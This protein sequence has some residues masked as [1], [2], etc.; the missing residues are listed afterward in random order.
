MFLKRIKSDLLNETFRNGLFFTLFSFINK[1]ISFV[2]LIIL[3]RY[4]T[5]TEYGYWSLFGTVVM[6]IGYFMAMTTEGYISISYFQEGLNG[7]KKTFSCI[8]FT[9][10]I[11]SGLLF[12]IVAISKKSLEQVLDLPWQ[13]LFLAVSIAFFTV[14]SNVYLDFLRIQKNIVLYGLFSCG[15]AL[16]VLGSSLVFV[17]YFLMGWKGCALAQFL[18]FAIFGIVGLCYFSF[19]KKLSIPNK[20]HWIAMLRWG[21]PLIP[22]LA[23]TFIRLGC[24]RYIINHFYSLEMVGIFSFAYALAMSIST[25]GMGFNEANS[26]NIYEILGNQKITI[27]DKIRLLKKQKKIVFTVYLCGFILITFLCFITI[28]L[29]FPKYSSSITYF[30]ILAFFAFLQCLY[31]LY[32]N[33]LFYFK[34][35]SKLMCITFSF[36]FIHL[37]LSLCFTCYSVYYTCIIYFLTQLGVV[38]FVRK[39]A[40][41]LLEQNFKCNIREF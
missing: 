7:V 39:E 26:I 34:S 40:I 17:K 30:V 20:T 4:I 28:P 10:L 5:P 27:F 36:A 31:F 3:A 8:L 14:F 6:F 18:G 11:V 21:L 15:N 22:H 38:I 25:I 9:A 13:Y 24:D 19:S 29:A 35:T 2:L 33:F 23:T 41:K 32:T 37:L 1:G 16:V 12:F